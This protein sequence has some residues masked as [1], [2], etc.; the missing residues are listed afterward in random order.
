MK[1]NLWCLLGYLMLLSACQQ[2]SAPLLFEEMQSEET[3]ITFV[4]RLS[5][6]E[7]FNIIEYLYYYNGGGVAIG[8]INN[9]GLPDIYFTANEEANKLYLNEGSLTF[10]DITDQAGVASPGLWKTGASMVDVNGD[11]WLDIYQTR[12]SQYKGLQGQNELYLNNGDLTFTEV[13]KDWGVDFQGFS[14]HSGFF[15]MDN[16]GDP[17][18]YL[19]NHAV[20]TPNSFGSISLRNRPDSVSGDRIYE[21]TGN[22]F[23]DITESAG[24][25]ASAIGYGLG[26]GFT[27][28]DRDG[29][30]DIYISNDFSENDYLY[31]NNGDQTFTEILEEV[32]HR[33]S[34]FSMGNDLADLNNDGLVDL[35]TLDMMPEDEVIRKRS[36]GDDSYEVWQTRK[37]LGYMDQF[38]RNS[39]LM[40]LGNGRMTDVSLMTGLYATD[41]SWST[42]MADFNQDGHKDIFIS[43]GIW[44]RPNDLDFIDFTA[45][46][47]AKD[48][49]LTDAEFTA[50]MPTGKVKNYFFENTGNW[51]FRNT[52]DTWTKSEAAVTNGATYADLDL[53]GDLDLVLNNLNAES[54]IL[55]NNSRENGSHYL[56]IAF[57]NGT[58][59]TT[60]AGVGISCWTQGQIQYYEHFAN[61]G[62]QS[63][64]VGP[65]IIGL[66]D[67]LKVDSLV[68]DFQGKRLAKYEL[69]ADQSVKIDL[70]RALQQIP[71]YSDE[72]WFGKA[73]TSFRADFIHQENTYWEFTR[74][75][76]MPHMNAYEGPAFAAGDVNQDGLEDL[77]IGGAQRQS[78]ALFLQQPDGT[79]Q[80]I[81]LPQDPT[82]ED[83]DAAFFDF[84]KD[85]DMDLLVVSGGNA[86]TGESVYRQ[87]R[88]Y[89]QENGRFYLDTL[90]LPAIYHTGSVVA[91]NDYNQDGFD[92][93]FLGSLV[94]PWNYGVTPRSYLL[95]NQAGRSFSI[96]NSEVAGIES[97][98]MIKDAAWADLDGNG[99]K[100]L[101]IAALWQPVKVF[102]VKNGQPGKPV[103]IFN[104]HGW[105]QT[106]LPV[107][108]DQDGDLDLML[109]NLG[110]NTKLKA[111][112]E[113]PV[114]LY[115]K[116]IDGNTRLD[117]VLTYYRNGQESAFATKKDLVKPL[118]YINRRIRDYKGYA[119]ASLPEIFGKE[120]FEGAQVLEA[121]EFRSGILVNHEDRFSF[122]PF[123][124]EAQRTMIRSIAYEDY[125]S[126]GKKDLFLAGN[127]S[128]STLQDA[129]YTEGYG[130]LYELHGD[131]LTLVP[132]RVHGIYLEGNVV[133]TRLF[134][135][136]SQSRL[137]VLKNDEPLEWWVSQ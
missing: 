83:V 79:F 128:Q 67:R 23:V 25:Y 104:K 111:S 112:K 15:D 134:K 43:N 66:G 60:L 33:T 78:S 16:D 44:K 10:K 94:E 69:P 70:Q 75:P 80:P 108:Y 123:S 6:T 61:R 106:V 49:N 73:E 137:L 87:P 129:P 39:V 132:N 101:I 74:E 14:T 77:F 131:S 36:A 103:N 35:M 46:D 41:W 59:P 105:W 30:T 32:A 116:D 107:D 50:R 85:G 81:D 26:I 24:I 126:D 86:F 84:E 89:L 92:D 119:E 65:V 133:A 110:L 121:H 40:N 56:K 76:L 13:A 136:G 27:D 45:S 99:E 52:S 28:F 120:A 3:G 88:L 2:D 109:G 124:I 62:F 11:G 96:S 1:R 90:A 114:R 122:R 55:K 63:S 98:G 118:T 97:A 17:D 91:V 48:P 113:E 22:S 71:E 29:F 7:A 64:T 82:Y 100:D 68:V 34:R 47:L 57:F 4:N 18:L 72:V 9:D 31:R 38:G 5:E 93:L 37:R 117:H 58:D 102:Y 130:S 125:N 135:V 51:K 115:L 8:D 19:L 95:T 12:V 20:H 127:F 53:D 21:N 54:T 42:L